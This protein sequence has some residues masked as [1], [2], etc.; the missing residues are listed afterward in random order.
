MSLYNIPDMLFGGEFIAPNGRIVHLDNAFASAFTA[1]YLKSAREK[2]GY[3][4]C[5]RRSLY[6]PKVRR[7]VGDEDIDFMSLIPADNDALDELIRKLSLDNLREDDDDVASG[8]NSYDRVLMDIE[9]MNHNAVATL[10]DEGYIKA[11]MAKKSIKRDNEGVSSS[12]ASVTTLPNTRAR[13]ELLASS[14][15]KAGPFFRITGGGAELNCNDM[16]IAIEMNRMKDRA[17]KLQKEK[18]LCLKRAALLEDV[19]EIM[20]CGGPRRL[21]QYKKC[22]EWKTKKKVDGKSKLAKLKADW[23]KKYADKDAPPEILWSKKSEARSSGLSKVISPTFSMHLSSSVRE[24]PNAS[25][26]ANN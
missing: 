17:T 5:T 20:D 1:E 9:T 6:D 12:R 15:N 14:K 16:L 23:E 19:E 4:P 8:I 22:I 7:E 21:L 18:E 26:L 24:R 11:S 10:L 25:S 2:C 3:C 13:Q